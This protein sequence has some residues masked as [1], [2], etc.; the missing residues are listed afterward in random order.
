MAVRGA[1][2]HV[3]V[4]GAGFEASAAWWRKEY[5]GAPALGLDALP[6]P[7]GERRAD[8]ITRAGATLR[9]PLRVPLFGSRTRDVELDLDVAYDF[10][11]HR[12]NDAFYDYT[13]H[14]AGLGLTI[15]Y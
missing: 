5:G 10:V 14:A 2:K 9:V 3:F 15:A 8:R 1:L 7:G 6:L 13:S 4:G 11:R 12:S